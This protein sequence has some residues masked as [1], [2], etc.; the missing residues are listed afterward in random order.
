MNTSTN[1]KRITEFIDGIQWL[2]NINSFD[3]EIIIKDKDEEERCAEITFREDYQSVTIRIYPTFFKE[4]L[5]S[6]RKILL[7][8]LCHCITI[9]MKCLAYDLSNGIL[10][11]EKQI[12]EENERSTSRIENILDGLLQGRLKY[13]KDAYEKFVEV[14]K[15]V[16]NKRKIKRNISRK[17]NNLLRNDGSA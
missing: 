11:T 6:Q 4:T 12:K 10:V 5:Y 8:E 3:R 17:R 9:P 14:D 7:H 15:N 13:A 1:K 16:Q 2:F